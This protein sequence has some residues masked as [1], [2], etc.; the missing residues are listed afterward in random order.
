[1][2]GEWRLRLD[3]RTKILLLLIS[4]LILFL[5]TGMKVTYPYLGFLALLLLASRC[6][7]TLLRFTLA[8]AVLA[9]IHHFLLP[10]AP[11]VLIA[12]FAITV[13]YSIKMF[14]SLMAAALLIRTTSLHDVVLAMRCWRLPQALIIPL[15]VTI[16]YFPAIREEL[17]H[18]RNAMRLRDIP[19]SRKAEA[20]LVPFLMSASTTVEELSAAAVTRGIENPAKKTSA[21]QLRRTPADYA[22][23]LIGAMWI[24]S[25]FLV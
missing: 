16:R 9:G 10:I 23:L 20:L 1:M 12:L 21:V 8:G 7:K 13:N 6:G 19:G 18:I 4:N 22:V 24:A 11:R 14:P 5:D 2:F 3:P 17:R 25:V 15:S